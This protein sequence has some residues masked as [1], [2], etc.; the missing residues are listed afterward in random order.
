MNRRLDGIN[1]LAYMG[2]KPSTP[3][4]MVV[5]RDRRPTANDLQ[6]FQLG[7]WWIIPTR[8]SAPTNEV[9]ILINKTATAA[10]WIEVDS[11]GG[12]V[13]PG[14][15]YTLLTAD[16]SGSYGSNVGPGTAGQLL[17]SGGAAA[18]PTYVT[19]TA[20]GP[21]SVTANAS[22]VEYSM[23]I[24]DH[25]LIVGDGVGGVTEILPHGTPGVPL[26]SIHASADP[27][28]GVA[29]VEGGGTGL[30]SAA[31]YAVLCGGTT[32]TG[33]LQQV[34]GLG[35]SGQVLTSNGAGSLPSWQS[36][37]GAGDFSTIN[38]QTFTSNGTYTPTANMQYCIVEIVGAGGGSNA[39]K[40]GSGGGGAGGYCKSLFDAATIGTSQSVVI[41]TGGT[42]ALVGASG[43][44]GGT[45]GD[46]TF[47]SGGILMT[48]SG[49]KGGWARDTGPGNFLAGGEGGAATGGNIINVKGE[50]GSL[51]T[52]FDGSFYP[53]PTI[54]ISGN[55]GSTP[56][57]RGGQGSTGGLGPAP[58]TIFLASGYG[59]GALGGNGASP[60]N[61]TDGVCVITEFIE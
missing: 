48:A 9:W 11:G 23:S 1:P 19:P 6:N 39:Y 16:G 47:G 40:G 61:G 29:S 30:S 58:G 44:A 37:G 43:G 28:F 35:T 31:A 25:A 14:A 13:V 41:G 36:A 38:V 17:V 46:S 4:Q 7:T 8:D 22:T 12:K 26:V 20:V 34:S 50:P 18:N 27:A 59:A 21:L 57:G 54:A 3:T 2:V 49:G 15:Q 53:S 45:G 52:N 24:S 10:T 51:G 60:Y 42:G 32:P 56:F 5:N 55:G 33:D